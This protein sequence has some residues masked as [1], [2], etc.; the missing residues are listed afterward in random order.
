MLT[1]RMPR[2]K[3][4]KLD[5]DGT[6]SVEAVFRVFLG[7]SGLLRTKMREYFTR[8]GI[9]GA[10]WGVLRVLNKAEKD[11]HAGVRLTDIGQRV[12]I[13]PPSVTGVVNR[14]EKLGW[15]ARIAVEEDQ[16]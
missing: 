16:R 6:D 15:V 7:T 11:G 10:Q 13:T 1:K 5:L 9:S 8:F 4:K 3:T 14:L 12:L 2:S